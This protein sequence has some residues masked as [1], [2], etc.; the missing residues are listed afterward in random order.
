M[1][2]YYRDDVRPIHQ[3]CP[4]GAVVRTGDHGCDYIA[5]KK[6]CPTCGKLVLC[7]PI[8]MVDRFSGLEQI[9]A[10]HR[11][12]GVHEYRMSSLPHPPNFP[13]FDEEFDGPFES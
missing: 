10:E 13:V 12:Q 5:C 11:I 8:V 3:R 4:C 1:T 6:K 7:G 2:K 9:F